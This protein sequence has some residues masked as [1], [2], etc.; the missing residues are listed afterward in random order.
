MIPIAIYFGDYI[1]E[2]DD[3]SD[4]LGAENWRVRL[5][6]GRRFVAAVNRHGGDATLVE[7]PK[8]GI[9]GNTH[10]LF[11]ELNNVELADHLSEWMNGKGLDKR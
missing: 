6:L 5:E 9:N 1:P 4:D 2:A 11:A 8:I 7:L 3:L 10:L